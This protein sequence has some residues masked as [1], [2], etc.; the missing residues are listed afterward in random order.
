Y[1]LII[2]PYTT[3]FRSKEVVVQ[4]SAERKPSHLDHSSLSGLNM[5]ADRVTSSEQ[6]Q[7]CA[8][9]LNCL[10]GSG[11]TYIDNM[12]YLTRTYNQG[13]R[14]PVEVY[15]NGM[16]VDVNYLASIDANRVESIEVFNNDGLSGINRRTNTQGV[17]VVK[18]KEIKKAPVSKEQ[19]KELFPPT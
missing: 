18:L 5:M 15:V 3:L 19:L 2:Y 8:N 12:L 7:G 11:I 13:S 14:V 17:L 1:K 16:P 9:L 6:L 4:A 10:S